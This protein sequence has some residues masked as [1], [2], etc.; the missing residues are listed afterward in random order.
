MVVKGND[1]TVYSIPARLESFYRPLHA[2]SRLV[3]S[4]PRSSSHSETKCVNNLK[5]LTIK[6]SCYSFSKARAASSV[7]RVKNESDYL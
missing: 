2:Q 7:S 4:M 5:A 3:K 6:R 1:T